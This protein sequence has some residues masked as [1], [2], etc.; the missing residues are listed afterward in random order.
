V[1]HAL[2]RFH[3][4]AGGAAYRN[5]ALRLL[6]PL[7][8]NE[9][10][11]G[12]LDVVGGAAG[13][14]PPLLSMHAALDSELPLRLA[15]G[16][17]EHLL[18]TARRE[19]VGWCWNRSPTVARGLTGLAHGAGGVGWALLELACATGDGRFR[20]GADQAFRYERQF[21]DREREN[22]P[23]F[24]HDALA[25]LMEER[26]RA[27]TGGEEMGIGTVPRYARRFTSAWCHGAPGIAM[28]RL[29]AFE[30]LRDPEM[31]REAEMALRTTVRTLE[32]EDQSHC[33][34]HGGAGNADVLLHGARVLGD[35]GLRAAAER[36]ATAAWARFEGAGRPWPSGVR[37]GGPDASLMMGDAGVGYAYLRLARDDV[38]SVL[39]PIGP[40]LGAAAVPPPDD[41][42]RREHVDAYLG[43]TVGALERLRPGC[44]AVH[45]AAAAHGDP[46]PA[47]LDAA[48]AAVAKAAADA[49][50]A[51][52]AYLEDALR[53]DTARIDLASGVTD[54]TE[55]LIDRLERPHPGRADWTAVRI[56]RSP[57]ARLLEVRGD[58][59]DGEGPAGAP[60][61]RGFVLLY[62]EGN[63]IRE[64]RPGALLAL[65]VSCLSRPATL[66]ELVAEAAAALGV[67]EEEALEKK[68][69][70]QVGHA[71]RAG[72]LRLAPRRGESSAPGRAHT[73]GRDARHTLTTGA[74]QCEN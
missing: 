45:A 18:R 14:I 21:L 73:D 68:I 64:R 65:L 60:N 37:G 34:C 8:G 67:A 49:P 10:E 55:E 59:G 4:L 27:A 61:S 38:P 74:E 19:V 1:A 46:V 41:R 63:V 66:R 71:W 11:D 54:L 32:P 5:G 33:L 62:R 40:D 15:I 13:A 17:G 51:E 30:I 36:F 24:R 22:W 52:R 70:E 3:L 2:A 42:L 31:R 7:A 44:G 12:L 9:R 23:D 25:M 57:H 56:E 35:A 20:Y 47:A 29:R 48:R 28:T 26:R 6:E 39:L 72:V 53:V 43:H 69:V 50:P 58:P 16:L